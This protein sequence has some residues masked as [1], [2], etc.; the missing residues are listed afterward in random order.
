MRMSSKLFI[1]GTFRAL[2]AP[3]ITCCL[4]MGCP[5]PALAHE[6]SVISGDVV[7]SYERGVSLAGDL[8][9]RS[10]YGRKLSL[11]SRQVI[12]P[13][14]FDGN[15]V[16]IEMTASCPKNGTFTVTLYRM[17]P[18]K[19]RIGSATFKRNGFT[20][21][22]WEGVGSGNYLFECTKSPDGAMVT[23]KDVAVYSW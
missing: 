22:V 17:N 3:L 21:A 9:A 14:S 8:D 15:S 19:Q 11:A 23:S 6:S 13:N 20:K 5:R 7:V 18:S 10:W 4:L 12:G 16:G 2:A 1:G